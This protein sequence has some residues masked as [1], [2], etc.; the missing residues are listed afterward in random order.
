MFI[1]IIGNT[2]AIGV[3]PEEIDTLNPSP[4]KSILPTFSPFWILAIS[5][6]FLTI[7]KQ[8]TNKTVGEINIPKNKTLVKNKITN[9]HPPFLANLFVTNHKAI[10]LM[11][12]VLDNAYVQANVKI[13]KIKISFPKLFS[14]ICF[15]DKS[16]IKNKE[17]IH[18][19]LGQHIPIVNHRISVPINI[20]ITP[21]ADSLNP[22][23]FGIYLKKKHKQMQIGII[24]DRN[25][26]LSLSFVF[27]VFIITYIFYQ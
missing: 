25:T 26:I 5:I 3:I 7:G 11:I 20:P 1:A 21:I 19:K 18:N 15:T 2:W 10:L 23:E 9:H 16:L 13:R 24:I 27:S 22:A 14:K 12:K 8:T 17:K 6:I 4:N